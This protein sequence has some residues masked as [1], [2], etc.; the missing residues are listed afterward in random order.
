MAGYT[1]K[2]RIQLKNDTEA[3]WR[4]SHFIPLRGE[5][6]IYS[7][8]EA[9]PFF[10]IKVGDGVSTINE[11]PFIPFPDAGGG[12]DWDSYV[13]KR[14]AHSITFGAHEAYTFDGS[15]DVVVPVYMGNLI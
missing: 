5:P 14:L 1:V 2:T 9:H 11:L 15:A 7:T 8:D 6:I 13:P 3:N 4:K 12:I 10:R